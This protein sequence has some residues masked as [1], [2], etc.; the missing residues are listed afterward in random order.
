VVLAGWA[1]AALRS[2]EL[3][4]HLRRSECATSGLRRLGE[5]A[6]GLTPQSGSPSRLRV[7]KTA[8]LQNFLWAIMGRVLPVGRCFTL[9]TVRVSVFSRTAIHAPGGW[10]LIENL[11]H[12]FTGDRVTVGNSSA[13]L[14]PQRQND[15]FLL[16]GRLLVLLAQQC[17]PAAGGLRPYGHLG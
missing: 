13:Y 1:L 2:V 8:A 10:A 12:V 3:V 4:P 5:F 16:H 11:P 14:L 9:Q 6:Y 7:H 17:L 15:W